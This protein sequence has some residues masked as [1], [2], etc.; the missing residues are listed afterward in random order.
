MY[1]G[2]TAMTTM[3]AAAG[4]ARGVQILSFPSLAVPLRIDEHGTVRIGSTRVTLETLIGAFQQG[5]TPEEIHDSFS[6]VSVE[7]AYTVIAFYLHNR[8]VVD[9][10]IR[11]QEEAAAAVRREIEAR[12]DA[13]GLRA[14]LL[15]RRAAAGNAT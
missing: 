13:S 3:G 1:R 15:A 8:D 12:M 4:A 10:Y 5:A 14:R 2:E 6:T 11:R 9:A 7:D